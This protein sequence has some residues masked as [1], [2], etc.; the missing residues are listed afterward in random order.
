MFK[1]NVATNVKRIETG[2]L[3]ASI[4]GYFLSIHCLSSAEDMMLYSK[5]KEIN[6]GYW[7]SIQTG[8]IAARFSNYELVDQNIMAKREG[9]SKERAKNKIMSDNKLSPEQKNKVIQEIERRHRE[10]DIPRISHASD[11]IK[12]TK[13]CTFDLPAG[14]SRIKEV[15][16]DSNAFGNGMAERIVLTSKDGNQLN[17][18]SDIEQA[19][20]NKIS[21]RGFSVQSSILYLGVILPEQFEELPK[22]VK[23]RKDI[24]DGREVIVYEL[25]GDPKYPNDKFIIYA[26]PL[27]GYRYV[28][29]EGLSEGKIMR[30]IVAKN[31]KVFDGVPFPTYYEDTRYSKNDSNSIQKQ[32]TIE[33]ENASFNRPN[34]PNDFR[35][36]FTSNTEVIA[37]IDGQMARFKPSADKQSQKSLDEIVSQ[38]KTSLLAK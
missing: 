11:T 14:K 33:I 28:L 36:T 16:S 5:F 34:D 31:Y 9:E 6:I 21:T 20:L 3:L 22:D 24:L 27:L 18:H 35:V 23:I 4:L 38:A 8:T 17:Y 19:S 30:K 15:S 12:T 2:C 32:E 37:I 25:S 7:K 1:K 13:I 10:I 29:L 26:D